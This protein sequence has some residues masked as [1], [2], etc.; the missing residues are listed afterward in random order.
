MAKPTPIRTSPGLELSWIIGRLYEAEPKLENLAKILTEQKGK[1]K[2]D[3]R[4]FFV[5][6][7]RNLA[8]Q[9]RVDREKLVEILIQPGIDR[10]RA[11]TV[12][13]SNR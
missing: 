1:L 3:E 11:E 9:V 5:G 7:L 10:M 13:H 8:F 4:E 2:K 6:Q 12:D